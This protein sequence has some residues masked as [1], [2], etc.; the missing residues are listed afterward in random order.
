MYQITVPV[1]T[2]PS[3]VPVV[4][5]DGAARRDGIAARVKPRSSCL[6]RS[7]ARGHVCMSACLHQPVFPFFFWA[8]QK[9]YCRLT[10]VA[11]DCTV[12][13]PR[14]PLL[15]GKEGRKRKEVWA[16]S[17]CGSHCSVCIGSSDRKSRGSP[18]R[19]F[20]PAQQ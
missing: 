3:R 14:S 5:G 13:G 10:D 15:R 7:L 17:F 11:N 8:E 4:F 16:L 2:D 20:V 18:R 12:R 19:M 6:S 9:R 1:H